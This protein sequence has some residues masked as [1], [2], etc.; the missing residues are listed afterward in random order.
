MTQ[1]I[2][3]TWVEQTTYTM[4]KTVQLTTLNYTG[5]VQKHNT[6]VKK[7]QRFKSKNGWDTQQPWQKHF[8]GC[9]L[10]KIILE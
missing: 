5:Q 2:G 9:T 1:I 4:R 6:W 8:V 10:I 3:S 7:V